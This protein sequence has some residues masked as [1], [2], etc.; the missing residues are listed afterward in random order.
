MAQEQS[1]GILIAKSALWVVFLRLSVRALGVVSTIVLARLL[2]PGDFGL[3]AIA[4][5][6]FAL[7]ELFSEFGFETAI[8]Q[9]NDA[10]RT[11]YDTAWTL[12]IIFGLLSSVLLL[13]LSDPIAGYYGNENLAPILMAVALLFLVNGSK[14]VGVLDFQKNMTF[15]LEFRLQLLPKLMGFVSTIAIAFYLESYWALVIGTLIWK[16]SFNVFSYI[17]HPFRPRFSLQEFRGLFGFSKWLILNNALS[18][19]STR[20]P[21]LLLGKLLSPSAAG[22]FSMAQ[23]LIT[24]PTT[25]LVSYINRASYP[26]YSRISLTRSHLGR[27]YA[28]V[29]GSIAL[30]A[31]PAGIGLASIADLLVPVFLGDQWLEL[32]DVTVILAYAGMFLALSSNAGYV[33]MAI[34]EPRLSVVISIIRISIFLPLVFFLT[35]RQGLLGSGYAVLI[36]ASLVFIIS[37]GVSLVKININLSDLLGVYLRPLLASVLMY[38]S[39]LYSKPLFLEWSGSLGVA[40]LVMTLLGFSVYCVAIAV[41]WLVSGRPSGPEKDLLGIIYLKYTNRF[42]RGNYKA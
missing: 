23:E 28:K 26:A 16:V 17:L 10:T 9:N 19:F 4:M 42:S 32:I 13:T 20:T 21:E 36:S 5:S 22:F 38:F 18:Y 14:N 2:T 41:L 34:G 27:V 30:L 1:V 25:E 39:L 11:D 33:F 24:L 31:L 37:S 6:C 40:L 29:M 12:N 15:E 7:V 35:H 3:V 8:I